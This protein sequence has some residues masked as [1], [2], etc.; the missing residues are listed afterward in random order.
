MLQVKQLSKY[1]GAET[2]LDSVSL[3]VNDTE[4]VGLIGPNGSGKTTLLRCIADLESLDRG[5]VVRSPGDA[6]VGYLPQ[7]LGQIEE[8][9]VAEAI[10]RAQ[11]E[12]LVAERGY[13][14]AA[15]QLAV[16]VD[17]EA[18]M[19]EFDRALSRFEA[20]GGYEREQRGAAILD[21]L[22]LSLERLDQKVE[23]L[24]GGQKT[25]LGL[26]MLLL[27]EPDLLLLDEP[28]NHLDL[29]ALSWL[30]EFVVGF[31]GS[32]LVVSHDR[33]FLDRTVQRI[34]Y[35]DP[36]LRRLLS[37]PGNYSDFVTAREHEAEVQHAAWVQQ[38]KY[39]QQVAS[40]VARLKGE[41]LAI[42]KGTTPRQ[43]HVRRLARKKAGLAK[44]R[45]RKLERF[46]ESDEKVEKPRQDWSIKLDLGEAPP[47]GRAVL[48]VEDVAFGYPG[49]SP[50]FEHVGFDLR[51][52]ERL[53]IIGPNGSGKTTLVQLITG[54]L[55]PD[56]GKIQLGTG[57]RLGLLAQE[58]ETLDPERTVLD[59]V[60]H[61]RAMEQSEARAFL[62][63]FLFSGD[64]VFKLIAQC[65][66]GERARLQ[67]A[68]LM[69][70]GC[71]LLLLDEPLNHLD[72][73]GREHFQR[74][75]Q[76]F[77]GSVVAVIHDRAFLRQFG[78]PVLWIA[79]GAAQNFADYEQL[80]LARGRNVLQR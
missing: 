20:L 34:I 77:N 36:N 61:E 74:S 50:L 71:N 5:E 68:L 21:G 25:R 7:V 13:Q 55:Q 22:G 15:D 66:P 51:Y 10:A 32:V 65:S 62:H 44:S 72:I 45:E 53:A 38:E 52:G 19:D 24:S 23:S 48:A 47:G 18:A 78:A 2:I 3:V 70:R 12:W 17:S 49:R 67:I 6:T 30:E 11:G 54:D 29:D 57:V 14:T 1:F 33:E 76:A 40:D 79:D 31:R 60:L 63:F 46:L 75:L 39:V 28:T 9:T 73:E 35:L 56:V 8:L 69:L 27:Q 26:A 41:A 43:P 80:E 64:D 58:Q 37:Y 42:E 4:R 16:A 59:T